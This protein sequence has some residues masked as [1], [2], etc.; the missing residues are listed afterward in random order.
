MKNSWPILYI[1]TQNLCQCSFEHGFSLFIITF[2]SSRFA[3]HI[4]PLSANIDSMRAHHIRI[5]PRTYL[6]NTTIP[7]PSS[8]L[9]HSSIVHQP[10]KK[11]HDTIF[12]HSH[13]ERLTHLAV[14]TVAP[15]CR[16]G[17][18]HEDES[19]AS[20]SF[21]ECDCNFLRLRPSSIPSGYIF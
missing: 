12:N 14:E 21:A 18:R 9:I 2:E 19:R 13:R 8:L 1:A 5:K 11:I 20:N 15:T 10:R 4:A 17:R 7:L 16:E 6:Q 3:I